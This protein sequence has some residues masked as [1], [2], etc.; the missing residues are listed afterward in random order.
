MNGTRGGLFLG[1]NEDIEIALKSFSKHHI[2]VD[3]D[4][5]MGETLGD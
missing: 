1:W 3:V 2:D 4:E 5:K